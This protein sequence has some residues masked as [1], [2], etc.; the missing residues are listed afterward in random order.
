MID[1]QLRSGIAQRKLII[2][3]TDPLHLDRSTTRMI[4]S[5]SNCSLH[6][7]EGSY[8]LLRGYP[9]LTLG[10]WPRYAKIAFFAGHKISLSN[11]S[12]SVILT[13]NI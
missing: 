4:K 6:C 1:K 3:A 2:S 8:K 13:I 7:L 11:E 9:S 5:G 10:L 12:C